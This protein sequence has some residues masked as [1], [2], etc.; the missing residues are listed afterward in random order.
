MESYGW[1]GV[2]LLAGAVALFGGKT[3]WAHAGHDHSEEQHEHV[4]AVETNAAASNGMTS[5]DGDL[6]FKV[7]YTSGHLPKEAQEVLVNAHGG[8]AIDRRANQGETYFALPGAGI[9]QISADLGTTRMIATADEV[10]NTNLHNST[11]W[12][13][14]GGNAFLTFPANEAGKVFTTK[15]DGSLVHTLDAPDKMANFDEPVVQAYFADGGKFVP[16]D[17]AYLNKKLYVTTGYSPLDYV[18]AAKIANTQPF[19]AS[20]YDLAFGGKGDGPGQF[21]TGHGI[22][23]TPDKTRIVV[24]DRPN[25]QLEFFTRYGHYRDTIMLPQ[26][27]FP[28]DVD[29]ESGYTVVGCLHGEPR[30]WG[31]PVYIL[32][33]DEVI[34]TVRP[35]KE[36]GLENFQ[37]IHN[38]AM[39]N[40]NGTLY[41]FVQ[42][43]NPGDFAIL[44]QVK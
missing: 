5:G 42:A 27:A 3:A 38:A 4:A 25:A 30:D 36:L 9:I 22:T 17:V 40:I 24:A 7:R 21:G 2:F 11:I 6:K 14:D 43:W 20:W 28:C 12:Y 32:K 15:L 35:K 1:I 31:A 13:D 10:K 16:T 37:H 8:F 33:G 34:S 39:R 41:L 19:S 29:F 26:G 44:E 18:L 23:I